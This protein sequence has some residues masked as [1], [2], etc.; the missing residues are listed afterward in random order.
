MDRVDDGEANEL[1]QQTRQE[2]AQVLQIKQKLEAESL[3]VQLSRKNTRKQL[4]LLT[5]ENQQIE[6][7]SKK[8]SS[9]LEHC[10]SSDIVMKEWLKFKHNELKFLEEAFRLQDQSNSQVTPI[11]EQNL[12]GST[13]TDSSSLIN[14]EEFNASI[15]EQKV[16][17]SMCK[18]ESSVFSSKNPN[19]QSILENISGTL[20]SSNENL[21]QRLEN[22]EHDMGKLEKTINKKIA[23]RKLIENDKMGY[24]SNI[25]TF[26]VFIVILVVVLML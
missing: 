15:F 3:M 17:T 4:E 13:L 5:Q 9:D 21:Y 24:N 23:E 20:V 12:K 18:I 6:A 10:R 14:K 7:E 26:S 19:N 8:I 11:K 22:I 2:L 25:M 16:Q 1:I